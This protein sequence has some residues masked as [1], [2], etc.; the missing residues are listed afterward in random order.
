MMTLNDDIALLAGLPLFRDM[1]EDKLRLIAFGAERQAVGRG[2]VLYEEGSPADCAYVVA[3][4]RFALYQG[5]REAASDTAGEGVLL[6]EIA[7]ISAVRRSMTA[8][9]LEDSAVIRITRPLFARMLEEYPEVAQ[10]AQT[11]ISDNLRQLLDGLAT[12][13]P[14]LK[15]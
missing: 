10:L 13:G 12:I 14:R 11:R 4:G 3:S 15:G 2:K 8:V 5:G 1:G 7:M 6:G 9:A